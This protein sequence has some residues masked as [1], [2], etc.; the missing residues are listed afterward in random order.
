MEG[1]A[2]FKQYPKP[3]EDGQ[4]ID[5]RK[6][7]CIGK[8]QDQGQCGSCYAIATVENVDSV[9]C[10]KCKNSILL[11]SPQNII[12]CSK[13][14]GNF[15]CDG[16]WMETVVKYI[17]N[18]PGI[19]LLKD[20]PYTA[21]EGKCAFNNQTAIYKNVIGHTEVEAD[22]NKMMDIINILRTPL[23]VAVKVNRQFSMYRGGVYGSVGICKSRP[24]ELNHAVQIVGYGT[25]TSSKKMFWLVKNSWGESWGENGYIRILRSGCCLGI[26]QAVGYVNLKCNQNVL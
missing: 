25:D 14:Q 18:A 15:G 10:L 16:G 17:A 20:Y 5:L 1:R 11:S 3:R 21:K 24:S 26:C 8:V 7:G 23:Y 13:D 9:N 2:R 22:E 4:F 6:T 19:N 12:D